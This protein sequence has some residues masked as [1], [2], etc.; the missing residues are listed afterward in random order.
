MSRSPIWAAGWIEIQ[1]EGSQLIAAACAAAPGMTVVDFMP[2][3]GWYTRVLVPYLGEQGR[4]IGLNP[5]PSTNQQ[6]AAYAGGLAEKFPP[7]AAKWDLQGAPIAAYNTDG[8]PVELA[9]T[10][11]RVLVFERAVARPF[12]S[13]LKRL[14][15]SARLKASPR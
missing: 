9:G 7:A 12:L 5:Y 2:S 8:L 1:D 14:R 15:K 3:G 10:V 4:Y 11:D 13:S 6:F